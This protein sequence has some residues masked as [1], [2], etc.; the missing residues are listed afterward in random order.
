MF[1]AVA[2][3]KP[4]QSEIVTQ[5]NDLS[6]QL[7]DLSQKIVDLGSKQQALQNSVLSISSHFAESVSNME[8]MFK[9]NHLL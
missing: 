5:Q 1:A 6:E 4:T 2:I 3:E 9:H 7:N 8:P